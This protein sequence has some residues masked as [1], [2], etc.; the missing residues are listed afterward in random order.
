MNIILWI[1]QILF[2]LYFIV[3]GVLHFIVPAGLPAAMAWMYDLQPVLHWVSGTAEI[4]GG[5]GLIL[6]GIF[7]IQTRLTWIAA[8]GLVL[9]MIGAM[10]FHLSRGETQNMI[11]NVILAAILAFI[12]YG[13]MRLRPLTDRNA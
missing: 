2:G 1:L 4:L 8:W 12:A 7:R 11:Q 3:L 5:I 9:V 6:P 13:R 10:I